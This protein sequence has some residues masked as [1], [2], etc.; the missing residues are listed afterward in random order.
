MS[1]VRL[2]TIS[3]SVSDNDMGKLNKLARNDGSKEVKLNGNGDKKITSNELAQFADGIA[4][5]KADGVVDEGEK[6]AFK[7]M[8]ID[9]GI[10]PGVA[11][12]MS[13][14]AKFDV[15]GGVKGAFMAKDDLP[16]IAS[17]PAKPL[18]SAPVDG[19]MH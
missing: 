13:R 3:H 4:G 16:K 12:Q 14:F 17:T 18:P 2:G 19:W 7:N 1:N 6:T 5:G 9:Q 15:A 10:D 11:D 8:M